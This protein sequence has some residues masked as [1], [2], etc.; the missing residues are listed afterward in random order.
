MKKL[1]LISLLTMGSWIGGCGGG[2]NN[3]VAGSSSILSKSAT[4]VGSEVGRNPMSEQQRFLNFEIEH[5]RK[6]TVMWSRTGQGMVSLEGGDPGTVTF[7]EHQ[8]AML[9]TLSR[10]SEQPVSLILMDGGDKAENDIYRIEGINNSQTTSQHYLAIKLSAEQKRGSDSKAK[11]VFLKKVNELIEQ[12]GI[13]SIYVCTEDLD[14]S[15]HINNSLSSAPTLSTE[16]EE[17]YGEIS[18]HQLNNEKISWAVFRVCDAGMYKVLVNED[19]APLKDRR[20][21]RRSEQMAVQMAVEE[22]RAKTLNETP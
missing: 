16:P 10:D 6:I 7:S 20:L 4:S 17:K 2:D 8:R 19:D 11:N 1:A 9:V 3:N 14:K 22:L 15:A 13:N 5:G 12:I 21:E 18:S